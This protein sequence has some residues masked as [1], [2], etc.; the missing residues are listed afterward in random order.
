MGWWLKEICNEL[1]GESLMARFV[2]E[3]P[4]LSREAGLKIRKTEYSWPREM[5]AGI[6][7]RCSQVVGCKV[8]QGSSVSVDKLTHEFIPYLLGTS[9]RTNTLL[10][11][12]NKEVNKTDAAP[13][14]IELLG[15]KYRELC[16]KVQ[17]RDWAWCV[18]GTETGKMA[19]DDTGKEGETQVK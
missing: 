15:R 1:S 2:T 18:L 8:L 7:H 10:V 16:K 9:Y 5:Q 6:F 3:F 12:G 17:R 4:A 14:I 13:N 11:P 19:G